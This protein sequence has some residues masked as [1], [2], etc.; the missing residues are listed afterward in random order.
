LP[1]EA[2]LRLGGWAPLAIVAT[3]S[4]GMDRPYTGFPCRQRA[5][6]AVHRTRAVN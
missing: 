3:D 4:R 5:L 6:K 2:R 1:V